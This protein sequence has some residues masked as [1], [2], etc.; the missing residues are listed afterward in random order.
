MRIMKNKYICFICFVLVAC[1]G[2]ASKTT[3][4]ENTLINTISKYEFN[5]NKEVGIGSGRSAIA[6]TNS[7]L[8]SELKEIIYNFFSDSSNV[9][10]LKFKKN[11]N[12]FDLD[13]T[14]FLNLKISFNIDF[15]NPQNEL[16]KYF[17]VE[18]AK[19]KIDTSYGVGVLCIKYN[20]QIFVNS[21]F[22]ISIENA[23]IK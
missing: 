5:E 3:E 17:F 23:K 19:I 7:K 21:D 4:L 8:N 11:D 13:S 15:V 22:L 9:K 12:H 14:Q 2:C 20:D 16:N 18:S 1:I 6:K 10:E